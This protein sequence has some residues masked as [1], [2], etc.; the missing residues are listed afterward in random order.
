VEGWVPEGGRDPL[1]EKRAGKAKGS[2]WTEDVKKGT[3]G[4]K[5]EK[6]GQEGTKGQEK[7]AEKKNNKRRGCSNEKHRSAG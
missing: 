4:K 2:N 7:V 1:G 5:K 3:K 6:R